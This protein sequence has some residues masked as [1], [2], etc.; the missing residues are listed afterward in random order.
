MIEGVHI[1]NKTMMTEMPDWCAVLLTIS[2]LAILIGYT[3]IGK[4]HNEIVNIIIGICSIIAVSVFFVLFSIKPEVE[5]GRYRYECTIDS[6]ASFNDI[7]EKYDVIERRGDIWVLE[8]K[9]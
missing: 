1:L 6:Q 7:Y 3:M 9:E 4:I 8:V 5:T 2:L